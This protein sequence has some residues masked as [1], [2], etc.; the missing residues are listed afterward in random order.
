MEK[1]LMWH[2]DAATLEQA[3]R[4]R[5]EVI[6]AHSGVLEALRAGAL[7]SS[8]DV[9]LSEALVLGLLAQDVRSFLTVF[10]HGSTEIGEVLRIYAD[11]GVVK[12]YPVLS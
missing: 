2:Q 1:G 12:V 8:I 4:E 10:G 7:D 5:A 6:A 11:A 9:T 3:R